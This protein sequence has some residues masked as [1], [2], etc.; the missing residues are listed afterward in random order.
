MLPILP[1]PILGAFGILSPGLV[2]IG[3]KGGGFGEGGRLGAAWI[4][5]L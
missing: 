2:L 5:R 4:A 3:S 1:T